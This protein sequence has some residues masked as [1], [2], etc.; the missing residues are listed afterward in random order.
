MV[1]QSC[2]DSIYHTAF[3]RSSLCDSV[4]CGKQRAIRSID[5]E[6]TIIWLKWLMQES[7]HLLNE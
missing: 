4:S 1:T 7:L 2:V 5:N 6:E 3:A